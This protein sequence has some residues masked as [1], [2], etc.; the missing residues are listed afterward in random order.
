[1]AHLFM[2]LIVGTLFVWYLTRKG[3]KPKSLQSRE[4]K[5]LH[6]EDD[7]I[8]VYLD[9]A[10]NLPK[11][12]L[13]ADNV[14]EFKDRKFDLPEG[15]KPWHLDNIPLSWRNIKVE[16]LHTVFAKYTI[17]KSDQFLYGVST[18]QIKANVETYAYNELF[19]CFSHDGQVVQDI[20][21]TAFKLEAFSVAGDLLYELGTSYDLVVF[22]P[23]NHT[24]VDLKD[25]EKVTYY[26]S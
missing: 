2:T 4:I 8:E 24:L 20:W 19:F 21:M 13:M 26:F 1:M 14:V 9:L 12:L 11:L 25:R 22:L 10:E 15:V 16:E 6:Q 17:H 3:G 7:E 5:F 18:N 23:Q